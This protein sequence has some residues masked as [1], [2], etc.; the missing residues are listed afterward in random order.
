MA[1]LERRD[2]GVTRHTGGWIVLGVGLLAMCLAGAS[3]GALDAFCGRGSESNATAAEL[4]RFP[5]LRIDINQADQAELSCVEGIGPALAQRIVEY[6]HRV[7]R[8]TTVDQL[9]DI[10]GV[11]PRLAAQLERAI[12]PLSPVHVTTSA[13]STTPADSAGAGRSDIATASNTTNP[14]R[15]DAAAGRSSAAGRTTYTFTYERSS[16]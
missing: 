13:A 16:R 4:R 7:G 1:T 10:P 5:D 11:G 9:D 15:L 8:I 12:E 3:P 14:N 6:R 2:T